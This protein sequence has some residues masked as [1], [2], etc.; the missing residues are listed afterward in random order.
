MH[1]YNVPPPPNALAVLLH[2]LGE[3]GGARGAADKC[4]KLLNDLGEFR[5]KYERDFS[6]STRSISLNSSAIT[7]S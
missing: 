6:A 5:M 2:I 3:G 4:E 1:V 7:F